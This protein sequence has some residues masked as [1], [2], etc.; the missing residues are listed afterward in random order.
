MQ[1]ILIVDD[2]ARI[3]QVLRQ[4]VTGLAS[5]LVEASDGGEATA[6]SATER[7]AW[8]LIDSTD[9]KQQANPLKAPTRKSQTRNT[10]IERQ[11]SYAKEH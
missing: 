9:P 5:T 8:V 7:P 6:L 3:R 10:T 1:K 2:D 11:T 4:G